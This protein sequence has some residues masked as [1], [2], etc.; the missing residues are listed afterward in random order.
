[1]LLLAILL[2]SCKEDTLG[3]LVPDDGMTVLFRVDGLAPATKAGISGTKEG[4]DAWN[5]NLINSVHLFLYPKDKTNEPAVFYEK[6]TPDPRTYST[7]SFSTLVD[8]NIG[9]LEALFP[10]ANTCHAFAIA[11][12]SDEW[13]SALPDRKL[14]TIMN[15]ALAENKFGSQVNTSHKQA[16]FIFDGYNT[17]TL[18]SMSQTRAVVGTIPLYRA[19]A[20]F[21]LQLNVPDT[22]HVMVDYID[23]A[24]GNK[25]KRAA[26]IWRP[27]VYKNLGVP[28]VEAYLEY[29]M[30]KAKAGVRY[31]PDTYIVNGDNAP[32]ADFFTYNKNRMQYWMHVDGHDAADANIDV[33]GV[34]IV[35]EGGVKYMISD[36]SYTYPQTW[37]EGLETE[38]F[39][40]LCM[41]WSLD[42]IMEVYGSV[43]GDGKLVPDQVTS[44]AGVSPTFKQFYYKIVFPMVDYTVTPHKGTILS[45]NWYKLKLKVGVL[46]SETDDAAVSLESTYMVANWQNQSE[47]VEQAEVGNARYLSVAN[48]F[49]EM[50]NTVTLD[51]PYTSSDECEII[52]ATW[53]KP[54][55]GPNNVG[56]RD[57]GNNLISSDDTYG[58]V[59]SGTIYN[60]NG[61]K[62]SN[63]DNW[64]F[65]ISDGKTIKFRHDLANAQSNTMDIAP[66]F[67]HFTIRQKDEQGHDFFKEIDIVQYPALYISQVPGDNVFVD[68]YFAHVYNAVNPGRTQVPNRSVNGKQ[69]IYQNYY[70]SQNYTGSTSYNNNT[71][72]VKAP[73][74]SVHYHA[75]SYY[76]LLNITKISISAFTS[77]SNKFKDHTGAQV[78][79]IIADPRVPSGWTNADLVAYLGNDNNPT[80]WGDKA[81]QIMI[82]TTDKT[83]LIAP[84]ILFSS[85]WN[86][87]K[88][89]SN[90]RPFEESRKRCATYQEGGYPAGR[91]RL[92]TEAEVAFV[93][94]L[95]SLNLIPTLFDNGSSY[96]CSDGY[97]YGGTNFTQSNGT[98]TGAT[99]CVY[100]VWYWGDNSNKSVS[101]YWPEPQ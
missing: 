44:Q 72:G 67:I 71:D 95:Q 20:K 81:G 22:I 29:G 75:S 7:G 41:P 83:N 82:G 50:Y 57:A 9:Q 73:Y 19:A 53:K 85:A 94:N 74:G 99:R 52:S 89:G 101:Q 27:A 40:K 91:W 62:Q 90:A 51:I 97:A 79:Y 98:N 100:D 66:Y 49:Y 37:T 56:G 47:V 14:S 30:S 84:A 69:L 55:Y 36:P 45:N 70:Y 43:D 68:G 10:T 25:K 5:E 8:I 88:N 86:T 12:V 77:T 13:I 23:N 64:T 4:E 87:L 92:P 42:E 48:N 61:V 16:S 59:T 32:A 26:Q 11:N 63:T 80:D 24:D 38:P 1:M 33:E 76:D 18:R 3:G 78:E 28:Q 96:W 2:A 39:Y 21:T 65:D 54:Y 60:A 34:N 58:K 17:L 93:R 15:A 35:T 31:D 46:G 6:I